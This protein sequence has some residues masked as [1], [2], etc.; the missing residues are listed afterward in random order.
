MVEGFRIM[1][2]DY[3]VLTTLFNRGKKAN[4][5]KKKNPLF[6]TP[7]FIQPL[8]YHVLI[9]TPCEAGACKLEG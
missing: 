5:L 6:K 9:Q 2:D 7:P 8:S 4:R 3:I 1:N